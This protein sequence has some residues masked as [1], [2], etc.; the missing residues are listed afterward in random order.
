MRKPRKLSE[1]GEHHVCIKGNSGML[2]FETDAQR[3]RMLEILSEAVED[4]SVKTQA[5]C[6][7]DNHVHLIMLDEKDEL[8]T[9]MKR[10]QQI[11]AQWFNYC[12]GRAGVVFQRPFWSEPIETDDYYLRALLYVH[13]N[14]VVA[15]ICA[16]DEYRW[17]SYHVYAGG[18][19]EF[20]LV[21]T[22]VGDG[23]LGGPEGFI[24]FSAN[25]PP[26]A[27]PFPG[28]RLNAHLT[29]AEAMRLAD[30][31]IGEGMA[32]TLGTL[33]TK[34]R[35]PYLKQLSEAGLSVPQIR[36]ITGLGDTQVRRA[37]VS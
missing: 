5:Y 13:N 12:A 3:R 20:G 26:T 36:R 7:M 11:Y 17:S 29:D 19:D 9:V 27:L 24:E 16:A 10:I 35:W 28:S 34:T 37:L 6:L 4:S 31:S 1:S 14:P 22:S 25:N 15:G 21:D 33:Q 23:L 8:S 2:L 30:L 32:K 18:N